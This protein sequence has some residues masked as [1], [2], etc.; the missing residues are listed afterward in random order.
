[1]GLEG[2][3][4]SVFFR[5]GGEGLIEL[6]LDL[7][8]GQHGFENFLGDMRLEVPSDFLSVMSAHSLKEL[9]SQASDQILLPVHIG[10]TQPS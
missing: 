1:M 9:F 2:L 7:L 5:D 6:R 4:A 10:P 8:L 3:N